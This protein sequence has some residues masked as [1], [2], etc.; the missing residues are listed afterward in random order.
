MERA[1]EERVLRTLGERRTHL[2]PIFHDVLN[3]AG[4]IR[5]II[6]TLFICINLDRRSRIEVHDLNE[7][8]TLVSVPPVPKIDG[9]ILE[10]IREH[11]RI[12]HGRRVMR[13]ILTEA[14][15]I[16]YRMR[17]RRR[18]EH[19]AM[20]REIRPLIARLPVGA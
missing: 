7:D 11:S 12:H 5:E 20:A 10:W 8:Y 3:I 15:E 13:K 16:K 14:E 19:E 9:R 4:R 2:V 17:R 1:F 6:P 18:E